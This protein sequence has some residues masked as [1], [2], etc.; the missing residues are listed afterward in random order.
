MDQYEQAVMEYISGPSDRFLNAQF[1]IPYDGTT[2]GSCPDFVALDFSDTT[3]YVIEVTTT[4]DCK[5][6]VGRVRERET[7]WFTPLKRRLQ[8]LIPPLR[9]WDLHVTLFVRD[10][11]L[12]T[13]KRAVSEFP[14]VSVISLSKALFSWNWDWQAETGSPRNPLRSENKLGRV[15]NT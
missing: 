4:A 15:H 13:A 7:R 8:T 1:T 14:D 3:A 5:G 2:G 12:E 11:Q 9:K 10:E 6:L